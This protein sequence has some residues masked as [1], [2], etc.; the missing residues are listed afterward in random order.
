MQI[1]SD[2][3]IFVA[4]ANGMVGKSIC[5]EILIKYPNIEL[6]T[7]NRNELNLT[8][9]EEVNLWFK[10]NKPS[11]VIISAARVGGIF[12]NSKK[13]YDFIL[14]NLK[15]QNNIIESSWKYNVK[16]LLFLGSSC[17]YPKF[18][19]QPIKEDS[20][21]QG[22]LEPTNEFYALAKIAGIKLCESLRKQYSFDA[23]C[24][25][26]CNLYGIGDNYHKDDSHVIP[27][28]IRK[29]SEAK[30]KSLKEITCWGSGYPLREFLFVDDLANACIHV[31]NKWYPSDNLK[32]DK[33]LD[34]LPWL[35]VGS[36]EEITIKDLA[37]KISNIVGFNG[38]I[39]WDESKPDGTPRKKLDT[40]RLNN[41]GWF[42]KMNLD[43]GL[44]ITYRDYKT[45]L[46]K[47]TLRR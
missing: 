24:L 20:L 8:N 2:Q 37:L 22:E 39:Y 18:A 15:I 29:I 3:K 23:I 38:K 44:K 19:K 17:I 21:L 40:T 33:N 43:R 46:I 9:F 27:A 32:K 7:P 36:N 6:L 4:G 14:E 5:R 42:P 34:N 26:P 11:I 47:N 1:K 31:L 16:R 30:E 28:L 12:A 13:P 10:K 45:S 41:L 25:M 35:N